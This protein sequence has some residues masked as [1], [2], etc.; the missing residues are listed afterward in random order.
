M[1][2][3]VVSLFSSNPK[4]FKSLS[5]RSCGLSLKYTFNPSKKKHLLLTT[6]PMPSTGK[7]SEKTGKFH[8]IL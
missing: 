1:L 2:C 6:L 3:S 4:I 8:L 5:K 7:K